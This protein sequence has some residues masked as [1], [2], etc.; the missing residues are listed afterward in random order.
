MG[1]NPDYW[2][3][4]EPSEA[5]SIFAELRDKV[6][7]SVSDEITEKIKR[8]TSE[9]FDLKQ[10]VGN[11]ATLEREAKWAKESFERKE[12]QLATAVNSEMRRM[13]AAE[14]LTFLT[15]EKFG[16][17]V[18][19]ISREKCDKCDEDRHI[20]YLTPRGRESFEYCECKDYDRRY[21]PSVMLVKEFNGTGLDINVWYEPYKNSGGWYGDDWECRTRHLQVPTSDE[22]ILKDPT[23][24]G[25]DTMEEAQ[26]ICDLLNKKEE[27]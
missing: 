23:S 14:L 17:V 21:V 26:R 16:I 22:E 24:Y 8:L 9:N 15:E 27:E 13:R 2:D 11:L 6:Y 12:A 18:E 3:E 25:F 19:R 10:R 20:R 5:D 7:E 4:R 1:F